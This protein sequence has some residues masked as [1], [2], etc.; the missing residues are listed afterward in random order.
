M[1]A[2]C[3]LCENT[4]QP[5]TARQATRCS[6]CV[7]DQLC[8]NACPV[9]ECGQVPCH[10]HSTCWETHLDGF[11]PRQRSRHQ[12][13]NPVSEKFVEAVTCS[14]TSDDQVRM[15]HR[16][17]KPARWFSVCRN[18]DDKPELMSSDRFRN[19]CDPGQS[20]NLDNVNHY[21]SIVSFIGTTFAGKSTIVR[22]MLLL[23]LAE[24]LDV[25]EGSS[26]DALLNMLSEV[27]AQPGNYGLPVAQG[28]SNPTTFGVHLYR[29][30]PTEPS[31]HSDRDNRNNSCT[32]T[33]Y[34]QLFADCEGFRAGFSTTN[35]E[36]YTDFDSASEY[37]GVETLEIT[38]DD[39]VKDK[40]GV[41]LF[42]A[43]VLHAISDVIVF[44]TNNPKAKGEEFP[45]VLEW[46]AGALSNSF[47]QPSRK[48]LII[49][50]NK[51]RPNPD[52][53]AMT[54]ERLKLDF[55]QAQKECLWKTS[56]I[57]RE[58]VKRHN[59][60]AT[61]RR[62]INT[63]NDLYHELF[64][65]IHFCSIIDKDLG[66]A[67]NKD[68]ELLSQYKQLKVIIDLAVAEEREIREKAL[69]QYN[70]EELSSFLTAVFQHFAE[71]SAPLDFYKA[72]CRDNPS[73]SN[74]SEHISNF[75]RIIFARKTGIE[76]GT[77]MVK[78]VIAL[79]LL[80]LTQRRD[81]LS[82]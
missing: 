13:V 4:V 59:A 1:L 47:N 30:G 65:N 7:G 53:G 68:E 8:T 72:T 69:I 75:L 62:L 20:G 56:D 66:T 52:E 73:P 29:T 81:F 11:H 67:Y 22:A 46:A 31:I 9:K 19:L 51:F 28:G 74:P 34:F 80:I 6:G 21:P 14:N 25:G 64:Q 71:S 2:E 61:L 44:I 63:N 50:C 10:V 49:V 36:A 35:A 57:L 24:H 23:E 48:T 15:L 26:D 37:E 32:E 40:T 12:Q 76:G 45:K 18:K 41:D 54:S 58:F 55:Y 16:L 39:Y 60:V 33:R 38:A 79:S 77:E 5:N 78:D 82:I 3:L 43:R 17:D 42:Y 27:A 70:V